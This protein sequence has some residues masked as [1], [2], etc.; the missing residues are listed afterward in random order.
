MSNSQGAFKFLGVSAGEIG[1]TLANR[2][3]SH[4]LPNSEVAVAGDKWLLSS[5][6]QKL[7]RRGQISSAISVALTLHRLDPGY[8]ARRLPII[9]VEDVGVADLGACV[10]VLTLCSSV[11]WWRD[12]VHRTIGFAVSSLANAVKCRAACD[13]LCLGEAAGVLYGA[14][15]GL[16]SASSTELVDVAA[17]R[18]ASL[19][20][21]INALRALGGVN[22]K[23][24]RYYRCIRPADLSALA[25]V[26]QRLELPASARWI[27]HRQARTGGLAAQ[28]PI[29]LEAAVGS[30]VTYGPRQLQSIAM[31]DGVPMCAIDQFSE[32][33][34]SV[35]TTFFRQSARLVKFS[36]R[37]TEP[38][39]CT[40]V[41]SMALFHVESGILDRR[42]TSP[43]LDELTDETESLELR[44]RGLKAGADR[45][46]IYGILRGEL[47]RLH[48]LRR[49]AISGLRGSKAVAEDSK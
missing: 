44:Q 34:K 42:L 49:A 41:F 10:D 37:W 19:H 22:V 43:M 9:A 1:Y 18:S 29:A 25:E 27:M 40:A 24:G 16:M 11:K 31:I 36:E 45:H 14:D 6:L 15:A 12:D 39:R 8:L 35:L 48:E 47:P 5:A 3:A 38:R 26:T 13:A 46:E 21:R 17:D 33:G 28:L 2:V 30:R 23:E 4:R 32:M 20:A 7:I